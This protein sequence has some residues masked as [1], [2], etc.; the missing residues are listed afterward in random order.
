MILYGH[1]RYVVDWAS[2][3]L[4][5][6]VGGEFP[7]T[8]GIIRNWELVAAVIYSE[9][10][11]PDIHASIVSTTPAWCTRRALRHILRYPFVQLGCKRVT[12]VTEATNHPAREFLCRLG[13]RQEG[14]HPDARPTGD[15]VSYGLLARD[16]AKWLAEEGKSVEFTESAAGT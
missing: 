7:R 5:R 14:I 2:R 13:F 12:A 9:Y 16:A 3:Q 10:K 4:G 11:H 1:D 8:I 15:A 6:S